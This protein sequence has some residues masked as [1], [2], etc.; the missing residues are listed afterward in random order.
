MGLGTGTAIL[1]GSGISGASSLAGGKK[2][3]SAATQAAQIQAQAAQQALQLQKQ[4]YQANTANISPYMQMGTA[5]IPAYQ[6]YLQGPFSQPI[7]TSL[8]TFSYPQFTGQPPAPFT[9]S[10]TQAQIAATP[11]YQF[12]QRQAFDQ[13]MG[14][15]AASGAKLGSTSI[16]NIMDLSNQLA[17]TNWQNYYNAALQQYQA[18][19]QGYQANLAGYTTNFNTA[20]SQYTSNIQAKLDSMNLTL[21]QKQQILAGLAQ[22][23]QTGLQGAGA[24][25]NVGIQFAN[26]GGNALQTG[27]AALASG[28]IGAANA[29]TQGLTGIGNAATSG[30][31]N[32][33]Q[34]QNFAQLL[35]LGAGGNASF[36]TA[37]LQNTA[38]GGASGFG[39]G[40]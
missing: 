22:P 28:Q 30:I 24:L 17:G 35:G 27:A 29:L 10:P 2:G 1:L 12:Q 34:Q 13:G 23:V 7:D 6:N 14:A 31:G 9:F 32:Y 36:N 4:I 38:L 15:A 40:S 26:A 18:G 25:A 3:A 11:G 16:N 20:S 33:V 21:A 39:L 19:L 5:A 8:P 37:D